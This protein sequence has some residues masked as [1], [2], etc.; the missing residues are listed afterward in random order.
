MSDNPM[1]IRVVFESNEN[2]KKVAQIIEKADKWLYENTDDEY[3]INDYF[4]KHDLTNGVYFDSFL[5]PESIKLSHNV[6]DLVFIGS[7][8]EDLDKDIV[9]WLALYGAK[10]V[11][12]T[13]FISQ[14]G[15]EIE[16]NYKF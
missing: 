8:S 10:S 7:P 3:Y 16:M 1:K 11:K 4:H 2:A 15:E 14:A 9:K 13:L 6:L 12:G 5:L